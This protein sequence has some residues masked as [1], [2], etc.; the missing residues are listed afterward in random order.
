[1]TAR[2]R[3]VPTLDFTIGDESYKR[4]FGMQPTAM[5][6]MSG[7]AA[8]GSLAAFVSGQMPWTMKIAKRLVNAKALV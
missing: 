8:V 4:L 2:T 7:S 3:D 6:T 5:W 1:M